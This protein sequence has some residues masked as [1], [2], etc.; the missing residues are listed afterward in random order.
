MPVEKEDVTEEG[1]SMDRLSSSEGP[2]DS[3]M[4]KTWQASLLTAGNWNLNACHH[5]RTTLVLLVTLEFDCHIVSFILFSSGLDICS[6]L[7]VGE[8]MVCDC[9]SPWLCGFWLFISGGTYVSGSA[10]KAQSHNGLFGCLHNLLTC[11][12]LQHLQQTQLGGQKHW[13][14][15]K[16]VER[17]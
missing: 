17:P 13:Y 14:H 11:S 16:H 15:K 1:W 7:P 5:N 6:I 10:L 2:L 12:F 4:V 8:L 3:E 9:W